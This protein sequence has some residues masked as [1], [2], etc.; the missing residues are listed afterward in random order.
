MH[1]ALLLKRKKTMKAK[2][3]GIYTKPN[4]EKKVAELLNRKGIENYYPSIVLRSTLNFIKKNSHQPLFPSYVFVKVEEEQ[5]KSIRNFPGIINFLFWLGQPVV[6][7]DSE[8]EI[9]KTISS[10]NPGIKIQKTKINFRKI[11]DG[12]K[13]SSVEVDGIQT[14]KVTLRSIGYHMITQIESP[15]LT[16]IS[17]LQNNYKPSPEPQLRG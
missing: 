5:L 2:W 12:P 1:L 3:Y 14:F 16:I 8:I 10:E 9:M 17:A 7:Q 4:C 13:V 15:K 6:I 11:S